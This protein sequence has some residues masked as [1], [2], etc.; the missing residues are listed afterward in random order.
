MQINQHKSN[1]Q[2]KDSISNKVIP[3]AMFDQRFI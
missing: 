1:D 2:T 3:E